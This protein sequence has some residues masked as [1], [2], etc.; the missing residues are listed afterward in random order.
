[1]DFFVLLQFESCG[2]SD[3]QHSRKYCPKCRDR[4]SR[5]AVKCHNCGHRLVTGK[6]VLI[7]VLLAVTAI[8]VVFLGLRFMNVQLF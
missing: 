1:M 4:I 6:R 3:E 5:S 7:Y 8:A 2:E